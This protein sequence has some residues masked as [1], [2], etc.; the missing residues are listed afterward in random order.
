VNIHHDQGKSYK[1]QHLFGAELQVQ[2]FS[3]LLSMWEHGIFQAGMGLEK[4]RVP[5]PVLKAARK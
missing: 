2:R 1:G 3:P 5:P 4:L